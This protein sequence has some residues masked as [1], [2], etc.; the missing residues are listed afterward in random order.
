MTTDRSQ[1]AIGVLDEPAA[2][3]LAIGCA[4]PNV[5]PAAVRLRCLKA[6]EELRS[7]G[8][9]PARD[10][11]QPPPSDI[12]TLLHEAHQCL[13]TLSAEVRSEPLVLDALRAAA[14]AIEALG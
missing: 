6:V 3:L 12:R 11:D 13:A 8:A 7:A 5:V 2:W 14:A 10:L 4:D 1:E 9:I